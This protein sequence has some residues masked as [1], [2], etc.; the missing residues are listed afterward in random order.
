M[1]ADFRRFGDSNLTAHVKGFLPAD[2]RDD[3][4]GIVFHAKDFGA[5]VDLADIDQTTRPQLKLE[6]AFAIGP[7]GDFIV[8]ARGHV[9]EM[10]RRNVGTTDRLEIKYVDRLLRALDE[11]FRP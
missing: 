6:K 8:D 2:G 10:R 3:D 1:V 11:V 9:A 7:Q 4:W 5:H